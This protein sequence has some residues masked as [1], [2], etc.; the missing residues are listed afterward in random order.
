MFMFTRQSNILSPPEHPA[1]LLSA[2]ET[3]NLSRK[4]LDALAGYNI[5]D[6][7]EFDTFI[8]SAVLKQETESRER[9]R[10]TG[11]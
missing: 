6:S 11:K 1:A 8:F 9:V 3:R 10:G 2:G 5:L 7:V 4:K